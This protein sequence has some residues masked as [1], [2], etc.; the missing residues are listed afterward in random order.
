MA[1]VLDYP[2][3]Q[4]EEKEHYIDFTKVDL[5]NMTTGSSKRNRLVIGT[6]AIM[7]VMSLT[8]P[9]EDRGRLAATWLLLGALIY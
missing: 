1:I 4:P 9:S 5:S 3:Q 6:V 7:R 8:G 2:L